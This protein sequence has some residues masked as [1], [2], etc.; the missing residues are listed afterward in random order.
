MHIHT[1]THTHTHTYTP[2]NQHTGQQV[3]GNEECEDSQLAVR[4]RLL[5]MRF[6]MQRP[7]NRRQRPPNTV[8]QGAPTRNAPTVG[9][10]PLLEG[11][12]GGGIPGHQPTQ[13]RKMKIY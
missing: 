6:L 5:L 12:G 4:T 2:N 3:A 11:G 9:N 8:K 7:V 13:T 10:R 1:H